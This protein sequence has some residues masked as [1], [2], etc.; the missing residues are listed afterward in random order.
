MSDHLYS[1]ETTKSP[2]EFARDFGT[3]VNKYGFIVHNETHMDMAHL[4]GEHG[5]EVAEDFDMHMIQICKPEKSAKSLQA[6]AE[7]A[8]LLPKFVVV[9]SKNDT[10]Q[11]RFFYFSEENIRAMVD[12]DVFP[13]SLAQTYKKIISMIDE[14]IAS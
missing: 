7:R 1:V 3:V 14:T 8:I 12:D 10:T 11:I 9:F 5:A 6:N 4:F 13:G 2:A